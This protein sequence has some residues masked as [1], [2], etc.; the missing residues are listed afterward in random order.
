MK[1]WWKYLILKM[2]RKFINNSLNKKGMYQWCAVHTLLTINEE[3]LFIS[4]PWRKKTNMLKYCYIRY[5]KM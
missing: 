2:Q 3:H 1:Q 5:C 4:Y